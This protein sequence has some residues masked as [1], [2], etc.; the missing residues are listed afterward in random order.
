MWS[1][2]VEGVTAVDDAL[3][4][5]AAQYRVLDDVPFEVSALSLHHLACARSVRD[6]LHAL[7]GI[8][9][10]CLLAAR[11]QERVRVAAVIGQLEEVV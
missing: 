9:Y 8:T 11:E 6:V 5:V 3:A 2:A 1:E 4:I 10:R 7:E